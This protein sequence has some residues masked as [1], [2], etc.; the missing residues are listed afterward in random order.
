MP[1]VD[2]VA[3][4]EDWCRRVGIRTHRLPL[5]DT[6]KKSHLPYYPPAATFHNSK[7]HSSSLLKR[8]NSLEINGLELN[9]WFL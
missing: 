4:L 8:N 2:R 6:S 3:S 7:N 5:L 1:P 9:G